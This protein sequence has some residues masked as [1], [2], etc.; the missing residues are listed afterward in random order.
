MAR[1]RMQIT[2]LEALPELFARSR[3]SS[4]LA[5]AL[6][7]PLGGTRAEIRVR[8]RENCPDQPGVYGMVSAMGQLIYVG[9]SNNLRRRLQSYFSSKV[10]RTKER[11]IG[12]RSTT[13]I[14]QPSA[15]E[16]IA[17]LRERELIRLYRPNYNVQG[18][19]T[20]MKLGYITLIDQPAPAFSL[21]PHIPRRHAGVWGPLPLTRY[22]RQ[23]VGELNQHFQL[24]DCPRETPIRFKNER[25]D[26]PTTEDKSAFTPCIRADLKTCLAPCVGA[27]TKTAYARSVQA[28]RKFLDGKAETLFM[29]LEQDMQ[30]SVT[31]RRYER[32]AVI[33]DRLQLLRRVDQ[34]LRRFH[35]WTSHANFL[36]PIPSAF[37][38]SEWWL[39]VARGSVIEILHRPRD[40]I[41]K[42]QVRQQLR[43]VA[44]LL[45]GTPDEVTVTGPDE[46]E[47]SRLLF[48]WFR[49]FPEEKEHQFSLA[50]AQRLCQ[51]TGGAEDRGQGAGL[52]SL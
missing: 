22:L 27:C 23:A 2:P 49:H 29:S 7:L 35:D 50:K 11:R 28:A 4:L 1:Q 12:N 19:P 39:V 17:R 15:H 43:G 30:V 51:S 34:H 48:R 46:F 52:P 37:D 25:R 44:P 26:Q 21:Q 20:G 40:A 42:Q 24:R 3:Y 41:Q 14:W 13:L 5:P 18:H 36:Y 6:T 47:S 45:A 8:L 31:Q 32:A 16:L 38:G 10:S 33:R 9:M